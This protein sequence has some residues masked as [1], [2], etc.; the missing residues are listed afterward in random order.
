MASLCFIN[1]DSTCLFSTSRVSSPSLSVS[2]PHA[3]SVLPLFI[4]HITGSTRGYFHCLSYFLLPPSPVTFQFRLINR[5][6]SRPSLTILPTLRCFPALPL[7]F[8]HSFNPPFI[9]SSAHH[10]PPSALMPFYHCFPPPYFP[11]ILNLPSAFPLSLHPTLYLFPTSILLLIHPHST[12][13]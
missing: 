7:K 2:I 9:F 11:L 3:P 5:R 13:H 1:S 10:V 8:S 4:M 6:S 12:F